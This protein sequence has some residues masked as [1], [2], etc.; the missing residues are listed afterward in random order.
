MVYMCQCVCQCVTRMQE[1]SYIHDWDK[2]LRAALEPSG[3]E[4][5]AE[6]SLRAIHLVLFVRKH[7]RRQVLAVQG[8]AVATGIGNL[9]G[10][11]VCG[12]GCW[13]FGVGCSEQG[14]WGMH[15]WGMYIHIY[16]GS[17]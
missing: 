17:V 3:Y 14:E 9:V 11:K 1:N 10:N 16:V 13:A 5:L 4:R 12:S 7:F 15:I 2:L 6:H 8:S